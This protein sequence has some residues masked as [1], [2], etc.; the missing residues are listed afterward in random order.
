[1]FKIKVNNSLYRKDLSVIYSA[2][3]DPDRKHLKENELGL[4][5]FGK[6]VTITLPQLIKPAYRLVD[7]IKEYYSRRFGFQ[8]AGSS[9][10][11]YYGIQND[12]DDDGINEKRKPFT[13]PWRQKRT[14]KLQLWTMDG[15]LYYD[16]L[17]H[18]VPYNVVFEKE[19][20]VPKNTYYVKDYDGTPVTMTAY[21]ELN[22]TSQGWGKFKWVSVFY[23]KVTKRLLKIKFD[24]AIGHQ[25]NSWKGGTSGVSMTILDNETPHQALARFLADPSKYCNELSVLQ[26]QAIHTARKGTLYALPIN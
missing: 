17:L 3:H 4:S 1:M 16:H 13:L 25:K 5:A 18:K 7:G 22:E 23:P 9:L 2:W 19:E 21:V 26:Q 6:D 24:K 15:E 14:S 8:L 11:I 10:N 20:T 12:Y